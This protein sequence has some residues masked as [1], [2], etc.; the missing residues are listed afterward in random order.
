MKLIEGKTDEQK[1]KLAQELVEAAQS[2]LGMGND[3]YSVSVE[4]FTKDEWKNEVYP[5][6]IMGNKE[7]LI[8]E[9][10]YKM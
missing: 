4:D 5:N 9:P 10:G 6:E 8:K 7:I 1:Q 2:V 3:S